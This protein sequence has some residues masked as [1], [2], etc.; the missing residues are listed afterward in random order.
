MKIHE[1]Y[2]YLL[3]GKKEVKVLWKKL[4]KVCVMEVGKDYPSAI[5][6]V[7]RLSGIPITEEW[8]EKFGFEKTQGCFLKNGIR[9]LPIR[10][11]Y[12][13]GSFPIKADIHHVHQLQILYHSLTNQEL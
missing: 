8:L 1:N 6:D 10:D 5:V 9:L 11:L 3:D 13:R 4:D 12:F 2:I 7:D